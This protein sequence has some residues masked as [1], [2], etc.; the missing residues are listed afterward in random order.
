MYEATFRLK[1]DC[2]YRDLSERFPDAT[3]REWYHS[4]CQVL[5]VTAPEASADALVEQIKSIG[6]VLQVTQDGG[7][8]QVVAQSC[9]CSGDP[10]VSSFGEHGCVHVPPTVYRDGWERYTAVGFEESDVRGL[11]NELDEARGVNVL[12]K[13]RIEERRLSRARGTLFPVD[14]LFADMTERQIEALGVALDSGYYE[15]PRG[16][17]VEEMARKTT[18]ARATFEEHLRKAENKLMSNAGGFV[19]LLSETETEAGL[20]RNTPADD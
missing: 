8:V 17:S 18:V 2:T 15:E 10:V 9:E 3:V 5:E 16:A 13:K 20:R 7:G 19:R 12:A 6:D 14:R 1:H 11:L 4:D